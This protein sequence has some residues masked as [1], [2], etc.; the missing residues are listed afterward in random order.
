MTS[1]N[2]N[3]FSTNNPTHKYPTN[4]QL[5]DGLVRQESAAIV[6]LQDKAYHA[7]SKFVKIFNLPNEKTDEI[8]NQSTFIFLQK[9]MDG[10]YEFKGN[11]PSTYLIEIARNIAHAATRKSKFVTDTIENHQNIADVETDN[12]AKQNENIELVRQLLGQLGEP[13]S[14]VIRLQHIDGFSDEEVVNQGL[15][16]YSTIDSL[17]MKRSD[18]MKK[19][20]QL[21]QKWKISNN[22]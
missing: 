21:A 19:L 9:I 5:F 13:C 6:C 4:E 14:T 17:K 22:I 3:W 10:E 7:V 8:L 18:C 16:K 20:I 15:T 11:A 1:S 2:F 12:H